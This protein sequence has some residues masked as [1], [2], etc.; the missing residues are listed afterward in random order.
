[1][2]HHII[3]KWNENAAGKAEMAERAAKAFAGAE[4]I[5]GVTACELIRSCSERPNRYDLMIR[6]EVSAEGLK[7]WDDSE[8][9]AAWKRDFG[10]F[11]AS[12]AIFDCE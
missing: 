4:M 8:I 7:N 2:K 9:H 6:M 1:M 12:K 11:I 10:P 3:V 5:E